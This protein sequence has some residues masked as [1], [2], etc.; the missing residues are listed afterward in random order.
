MEVMPSI[1]AINF[2]TLCLHFEQ[3]SSTDT[4]VF[5]KNT[6]ESDWLVRTSEL[7]EDKCTAVSVKR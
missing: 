4:T 7:R 3:R 2:I 1:D 6:E 5:C